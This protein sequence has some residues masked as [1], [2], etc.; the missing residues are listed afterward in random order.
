[1]MRKIAFIAVLLLSAC[2]TKESKKEVKTEIVLLSEKIA[3]DPSNTALLLDRVNYNKDRNNFESALFDLKECVRLD[4]LNPNFHFMSAEIYFDLS[5]LPNANS[6]YPGFTKHHLEKTIGLSDNN[7]KA[8]A[9]MGEL[10][11]AYAKYK[12]AIDQFNISLKIEYNQAKT[13]MLMGYTFKQLGQDENA[14]NCFRNAVNVD[15]E[16]KE[17]FVQLGQ[18][19]HVKGDTSA[20]IY[21]NNALQLDTSDEMTLYNKAL[22]YQSIMDWNAA[23]EAYADLH[24]VNY[25]H[26]SGHY[27]KGFIHMELG[28]YDIA[29]NNFAD[30]IYSNSEFYEAYYS[31]GNCFE[32]LGN[33]KQAEIDYTRAIEI[34]PEYTFAIEA[35]EQ[36]QLKNKTFNK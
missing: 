23:L 17:A 30:A 36:L 20:V 2:G 10:L 35:L 12:E 24:K 14:I 27:N 26:S 7:Y 4:S 8:H 22:F 13:H 1:M 5:K 29:A 28:L 33:I 32:T 3:N 25:T 15:P 6:K 16:F 19:F 9:L 34:N 11:L 21:Y 18:M 31:R